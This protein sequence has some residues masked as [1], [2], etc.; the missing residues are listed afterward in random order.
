MI[1]D[2]PKVNEWLEEYDSI[3][4]HTYL[5]SQK[6][7]K[8]DLG[9]LAEALG[10]Y[11]DCSEEPYDMSFFLNEVTLEEAQAWGVSRGFCLVIA[12]VTKGKH[13]SLVKIADKVF[14]TRKFTFEYMGYHESG[15]NV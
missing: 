1:H 13:R 4:S 7:D 15:S 8:D 5:L 9:Y 2:L 6:P 14:E 10:F 11:L 12:Y 3:H